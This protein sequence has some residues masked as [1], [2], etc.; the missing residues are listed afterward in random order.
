M[1][2]KGKEKGIFSTLTARNKLL[3]HLQRISLSED[4]QG[5]QFG[6]AVVKADTRINLKRPS[7]LSSK[8]V[9]LMKRF[10]RTS[11]RM[12]WHLQPCTK[13]GQGKKR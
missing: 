4:K 5:E 8:V 10:L 2:D 9:R 13:Y 6:P 3:N 11:L 1:T 7:I 12:L